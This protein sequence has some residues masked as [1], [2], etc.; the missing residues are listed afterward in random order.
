MW[1]Q[2][3]FWGCEGFLPKFHQTCPKNTP[4][5]MTSKTQNVCTLILSAIFV[6]SKHI[7]RFCEGIHTFCPNFCTYFVRIFTKSNVLGVRLHPAS[8]PS[9]DKY[10]LAVT[11]IQL[12]IWR[13]H[14]SLS[15]K[16]SRPLFHANH[17]NIDWKSCCCSSLWTPL[18]WHIHNHNIYFIKLMVSLYN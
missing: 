3:N 5:K 13:F 12:K 18:W 9:V 6:K 4:K 2:A 14:G 15:Q 17:I 11:K 1:Q 7:Q 8:Y 16:G 10:C